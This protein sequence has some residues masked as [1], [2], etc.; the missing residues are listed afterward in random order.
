MS[1]AVKKFLIPPYSCMFDRYGFDWCMQNLTRHLGQICGG[2]L[3]N[4]YVNSLKIRDGDETPQ[5]FPIVRKEIEAFM[6]RVINFN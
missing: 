4:K 1:N 6:K 5:D 3:D 2:A